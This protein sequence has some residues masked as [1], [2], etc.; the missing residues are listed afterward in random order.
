M[1]RLGVIGLSEGNGHPLSFSAIINGYDKEGFTAANWPVILDYLERQGPE[2]FGFPDAR[3]T[4]VWTQDLALSKTIARACRIEQAVENIEDM[5]GAVDAVLLARDDWH[6]HRQLAEVFLRHDIPVFIDKP[7]SLDPEELAYFKPYLESG[8][9]MSTSGL[10]Y[11][12]EV[13]ALRARI[14]SLGK[15]K[16]LSAAVVVDME[17]YGVHMLDA[18]AGLGLAKPVSVMRMPAGHEAISL[19]LEDGLT[20][21]LHCLGM[22]AKTFHLSLYG[23]LGHAHTDINDNFSAFRNTIERFL[24]L[25]RGGTPPI[26]A[27]DVLHTMTVIRTARTLAPGE[28]ATFA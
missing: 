25:V 26:P 17:R 1:I 20:F 28:S 16:L 2:R 8:L 5:V 19:Q 22:V 11:A 23:E 4:A 12:A 3:V 13:E 7:L 21:D 9:V 15:L 27:T 18:A 14:P 10:R 24:G 6:C